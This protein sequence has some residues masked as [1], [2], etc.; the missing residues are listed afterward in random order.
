MITNQMSA[1]L[2]GKNPHP[3]QVFQHV[4]KSVFRKKGKKKEKKIKKKKLFIKT[5]YEIG[6]WDSH[7]DLHKATGKLM[8]S[9][10]AHLKLQY[11]NSSNQ[12]QCISCFLEDKNLCGLPSSILQNW[13]GCLFIFLIQH[14]SLLEAW[15]ILDQLVY[16]S[17]LEWQ[18]FC[19]C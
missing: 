13:Q 5:T 1:P 17:D 12:Q 9:L 11:S 8:L 14:K 15:Y 3:N 2:W 7:N 19:F 16:S 18:T 6:W 10:D 4:N